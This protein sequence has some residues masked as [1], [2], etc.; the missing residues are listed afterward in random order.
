M[1]YFEHAL[2]AVAEVAKTKIYGIGLDFVHGKRNFEALE[3]IKNSHLTLF[4]GIIDGRNIWKS[5]IDEKVNL[6]RE[7]GEKI[8]GKD[9]YV[10]PS[11]SLLHVPYTLKY[12]EKLNSEVKSWLSFAVEKL[13]EIKI[14][15]KLANVV[16]L[17]A[18]ESNIY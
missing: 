9:F 10:G 11:C 18:A 3:T 13:D 12:E 16:S 2:K 4:A 7:I 5:N 6:V 8:G 17:N 14:I 15:T 1:T